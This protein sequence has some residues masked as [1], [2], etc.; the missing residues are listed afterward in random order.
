MET[1][2]HKTRPILLT[3]ICVLSFIGS[4]SS[5]FSYLFT[6]MY[7]NVIPTIVTPEMFGE[8]Y[9]EAFELLFSVDRIY[10]L[11]AGLLH[12]G[13]FVGVCFLWKMKKIGLHIYTVAQFL[14]LIV[15]TIY[16]YRPMNVSPVSDL[17]LSLVFV[18][19]YF[20]FRKIMN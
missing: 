6:Y 10:Y 4:F 16:L 12:I 13:A 3:I 8:L 5:S 14:I 7:Y 17:F 9:S 20:R 1:N 11:Y 15:S 18:S 2:T 19:L